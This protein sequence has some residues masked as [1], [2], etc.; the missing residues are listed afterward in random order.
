MC[1]CMVGPPS[2]LALDP[3]RIRWPHT[4]AQCCGTTSQT[5]PWARRCAHSHHSLGRAGSPPL[6]TSKQKEAQQG[7]AGPSSS[8]PAINNRTTTRPNAGG[9]AL[10]QP[11]QGKA[12]AQRIKSRKW[13]AHTRLPR[14]RRGKSA[15]SERCR[16]GQQNTHCTLHLRLA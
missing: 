1:P 8:R 2:R 13:V 7:R 14:Q 16:T 4:L 15:T 12:R 9:Q 5:V 10:P 3:V 6:A 11:E